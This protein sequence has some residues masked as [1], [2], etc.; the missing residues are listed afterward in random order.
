M[1]RSLAVL[2]LALSAAAPAFAQTD[3]RG[4]AP[5]GPVA[6]T[7]G[8]G[9]VKSAPDRAWVTIAAESRAKSPREAQRMN[10]D[11]MGAVMQKLKGANLGAD[12]IRTL[13]YDLQPEFDY[14]NGRQT[15]RG[16][17]ARN[18]V[19]V[20][21]DDI[22]RVGEVLDLAVGSGA[23]SVSGVRFDLKNREG[24]ER[25]ALKRAVEDARARAAALAAGAGMSVAGVL[26]ID[27]QR[28]GIPPPQP[29]MMRQ[30]ADM[31]TAESAAPPITPGELEV[32]VAVTL[33][34]LLK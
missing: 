2:A 29:M 32:R 21:V 30:R 11:A 19:E 16:Y 17:V 15:L 4:P 26:R 8:E 28:L 24:V 18:S 23:T 9:I 22:Q 1:N 7:S 27:E 12:A 20:R 14:G 31:A 13:A 3:P 10:A 5:Q 34:V 6:V 25:E 33:T